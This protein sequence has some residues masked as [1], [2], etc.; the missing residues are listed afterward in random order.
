[1]VAELIVS[2]FVY[3][4]GKGIKLSHD[5]T[6]FIFMKNILPPDRFH[7]AVIYEDNKDEYGFL[8]A[9]CNIENTFRDL[10]MSPRRT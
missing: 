2:Q 1:M 8:Y 10:R 9:T 4:V 7:D 6:M 5:K 3:K